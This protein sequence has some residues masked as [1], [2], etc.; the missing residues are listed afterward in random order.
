MELAGRLPVTGTTLVYS[1]SIFTPYIYLTITIPFKDY[2]VVIVGLGCPSAG[3]GESRPPSIHLDA[4]TRSFCS[5]NTVCTLY[6]HI[7]Q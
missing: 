7:V 6:S 5:K 2:I 3:G 4:G 1:H